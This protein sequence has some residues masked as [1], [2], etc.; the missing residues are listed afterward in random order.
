M[1]PDSQR[2]DTGSSPGPPRRILIIMDEPDLATTCVRFL[3]RKGYAPWAVQDAT[4]ALSHIESDPPDLIIADVPLS[5]RA[6]GLQ[7][8]P[9]IRAGARRIP[10]ILCTGRPLALSRLQALA[11]GATGYLTKPF[12][13]AQLCAVI[14]H[15]LIGPSPHARL[16]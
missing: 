5:G 2:A 7:I 10:V 11:A 1:I 6:D 12:S 16:G 14:E 8:L 3:Q 15:A 9:R 13:L 4:E